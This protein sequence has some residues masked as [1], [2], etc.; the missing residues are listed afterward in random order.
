MMGKCKT[1]GGGS[2]DLAGKNVGGRIGR[3]GVSRWEGGKKCLVSVR[4]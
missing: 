4:K 2:G 3:G 1:A